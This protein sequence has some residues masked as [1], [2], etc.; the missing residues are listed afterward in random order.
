VN[1][2]VQVFPTRWTSGPN[3]GKPTGQWAFRIR[4]GNG[5]KWV[6][7]QPYTRK[8]SAKRAASRFLV[9]IAPLVAHERKRLEWPG[10]YQPVIEVVDR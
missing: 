2:P 4:A 5:E 9:S 3:K 1:A 7:S 8:A 10:E 6:V